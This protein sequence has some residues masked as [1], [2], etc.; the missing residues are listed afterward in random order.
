MNAPTAPSSLP[1]FQR[2]ELL[3][4]SPRLAF[5]IA[6][7]G[8]AIDKA[9]AQFGGGRFSHV[10]LTFEE[11]TRDTWCFSSSNRDK[12]VR[13]KAI[14]LLD[15]KWEVLE[16]PPLTP[17]A[18]S[19]LIAFCDSIRGWPYDY[20]G[21][22]FWLDGKTFETQ[23]PHKYFCSEAVL[24][25]LQSAGLFPNADAGR[26]SPGDLYRLAVAAGAIQVL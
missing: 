26:T 10:E 4:S 14:D 6:E 9:V 3:G 18:M 19:D 15:G 20:A 5:Y 16:L 11:P 7:R 8:N 24:E 23:D 17:K 25:A 22:F 1:E 21:L 2:K 13:N 12:G